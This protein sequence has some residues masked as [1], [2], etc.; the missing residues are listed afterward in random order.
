MTV[1][2][3]RPAGTARERRARDLAVNISTRVSLPVRDLLDE[4]VDREGISIREAIEVAIKEKW[5]SAA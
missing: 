3:D 2:M 5:G 1:A 4:V